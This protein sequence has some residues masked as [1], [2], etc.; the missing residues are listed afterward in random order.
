MGTLLSAGLSGKVC[1][2][3]RKE[4][5]A[6]QPCTEQRCLS[7]TCRAEWQGVALCRKEHLDTALH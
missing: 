4:H 6:T 1:A 3:C 7:N 2:L 5:L